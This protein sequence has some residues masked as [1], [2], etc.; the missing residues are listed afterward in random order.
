MPLLFILYY[1]ISVKKLKYISHFFNILFTY[2]YRF[3]PSFLLSVI[4]Y[5][6]TKKANTL[7]TVKSKGVFMYYN[8]VEICGV[9]TSTLKVL[10]DEEKRD[11]YYGRD[12]LL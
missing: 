6:Y 8:K 5:R 7:F 9:N 4:E 2:F 12:G 10:T 11:L 3:L 1:T